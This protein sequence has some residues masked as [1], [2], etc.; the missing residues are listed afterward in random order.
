MTLL[1]E[2]ASFSEAGLAL[3]E[4]FEKTGWMCFWDMTAF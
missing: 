3:T 2:I 4:E 1:L